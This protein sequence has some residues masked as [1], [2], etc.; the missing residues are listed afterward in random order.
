MSIAVKPPQADS[1][2]WSDYLD[3]ARAES[4]ENR[5]CPRR[6]RYEAR[7]ALGVVAFSAGASTLVSAGLA[8]A[9]SWLA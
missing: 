3:L 2:G 4:L 9:L 8:L 7:D 6:V 1:T 5:T